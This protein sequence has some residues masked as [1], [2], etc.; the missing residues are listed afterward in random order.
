MRKSLIAL[1]AA[2]AL[3]LSALAVPASA[4]PSPNAPFKFNESECH[5]EGTET[6]CTSSR[7]SLQYLFTKSG[8]EH[9]RFSTT[10]SFTVTE[11]ATGA[12]VASYGLTGRIHSLSRDGEIRVLRNRNVQTETVAGESCSATFTFKFTN[13]KVQRDT[14]E[15][16]C[17]AA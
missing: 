16:D 12:L 2:V 9:M 4:A 7:G 14:F 6:V 11:T 17:T 3:P 10:D 1:A 8:V 5:E 15:T 13:R